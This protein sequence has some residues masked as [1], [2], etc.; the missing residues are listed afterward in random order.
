MK[1]SAIALGCFLTAL[2]VAGC[3]TDGS[4]SG[5]GR[6]KPVVQLASISAADGTTKDL[7]PT[8]PFNIPAYPAPLL[9]AGIE[10]FVDVKLG[11]RPD[12]SVHTVGILKSTEKDFENPVL[13]AVKTWQFPQ[14]KRPESDGSRDVVLACR[15]SFSIEQYWY[16]SVGGAPGGS[17]DPKGGTMSAPSHSPVMTTR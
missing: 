10:G 13:V 9:Q 6:G 15:L 4:D 8:T 12:G 2:L 1:S 5:G 7:S 11:I 3:L 17:P 16:S 14:L